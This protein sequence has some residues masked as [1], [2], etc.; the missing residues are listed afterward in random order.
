MVSQLSGAL[1]LQL[2][3]EGHLSQNGGSDLPRRLQG[4]MQLGLNYVHWLRCTGSRQIMTTTRG[5]EN[6]LASHSKVFQM[7][8][9]TQHY[10]KIQPH[11]FLFYLSF[12]RGVN[13]TV[14]VKK[15]HFWRV[16]VLVAKVPDWAYTKEPSLPS[17]RSCGILDKSTD[18][19]SLS[20]FHK[21]K[22]IAPFIFKRLIRSMI[23]Q[24]M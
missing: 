9:S 2:L 1:G 5:G 18:S 14:C 6:I 23:L 7:K 10:S 17:I 15:I 12:V 20:Y 16:F 22:R 11:L 4:S 19:P 13:A 8:S 24:F 3:V 21:E